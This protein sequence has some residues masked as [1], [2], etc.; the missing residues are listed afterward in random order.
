M[1]CAETREQG[2][3]DVVGII[4]PDGA[5]PVV[6]V[7]EHASAFIP[8]E[9]K[10]LG[11]NEAQRDSHIAWD[12]GAFQVAKAMSELL[13]AP[14][15]HQTVSRLLYDCNRPPEA[16]SAIPETSEI[17]DIPG[18]HGLLPSEKKARAERFYYP[19]QS[20]L[21]DVIDHRSH[22]PQQPV[23]VTIHTFTPNFRGESR[24][25]DVGILHDSDRRLADAM[26]ENMR[27]DGALAFGRN[28][29]YGPQDGVTHTLADQAIPLGLLNVMIEIRNDLVSERATQIAM[30][31]KLVDHLNAGLTKQ[32]SDLP[33]QTSSST[34]QRI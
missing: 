31:N 26:L 11:L 10:G 18:N 19:F 13:D 32:N 5:G 29:P 20:A 9:F 21:N 22:R 12:P 24:T 25:L 1:K 33:E 15:V 27:G 7:C 3:S 14:L 6:L 34:G 8:P 17:H 2:G 28:K 16:P 4:N 23:L 30:A